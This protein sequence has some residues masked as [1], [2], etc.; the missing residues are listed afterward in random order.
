MTVYL[1]SVFALNFAVNWLLR[2][3]ARLGRRRSGPGASR[4]LRRSAQPTPWRCICRGAEFWRAGRASWPS[5]RL[6]W[7]WPSACGAKRCGSRRCSA[8]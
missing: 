8:G 1:D 5:R 2:A 4:R 6:C 7:P 3:A